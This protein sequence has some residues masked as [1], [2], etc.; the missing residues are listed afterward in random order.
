[1][2]HSQRRLQEPRVK[3]S[4]D[5]RC[6]RLQAARRLLRAHHQRLLEPLAAQEH[7]ILGVSQQLAVQAV[8]QQP[9]LAPAQQEIVLAL[10][11]VA[12]QTLLAQLAQ[13]AQQRHL[14]R[15]PSHQGRAMAL[16]LVLAQQQ[17][18]QE[19]QALALVPPPVQMQVLA[20]VPPPVQ[21]Q[22]LMTVP[23]LVPAL[24]LVLVLVQALAQALALALEQQQEQQ[25]VLTKLALLM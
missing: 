4:R 16:A 3:P 24:V 23:A 22:V 2:L 10:V 13:L 8:P 9:V 14:Q 5:S 15:A 12:Q 6:S 19:Q 18:Q 17:E 1:M 11:R 21:M 7:R 25:Q 20:L